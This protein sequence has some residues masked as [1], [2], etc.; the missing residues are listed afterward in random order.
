M[1]LAFLHADFVRETTPLAGEIETIL[2]AL[3]GALER[4]EG[5]APLWRRLLNVL[6]TVKGNCGIVGFAAGQTLAHAME[7]RAKRAQSAPVD[8]QLATARAL[9]PAADALRDAIPTPDAATEKVRTATR[10]LTDSSDAVVEEAARAEQTPNQEEVYASYAVERIADVRIGAEKLDRLLE[11]AGELATH[12]TRVVGVV[13]S[14]AERVAAS[15]QEAAAAL[16]AVDE[17]GKTIAEFRSGITQARLLPL[18][19]AINRFRRLVRDLCASTGK[20]AT[21]E[22]VG[23]E[24]VVDKTIVDAIG[25]PL[26][27]VLRNAVDH[28]LESPSARIAAGKGAEGH[29]SLGIR[30]RGGELLF[31]IRDDGRGIARAKLATRARER[32]VS[33]EG[34]SDTD[35]VELIFLPDISTA[36]KVSEISG[37]GVG[38]DVARK[39][40]E[41][42]GGAIDVVSEEGRGTEFRIRVPLTLTL[43]RVLLVQRRD[44]VYA[45]GLT[46]VF[47]IVRGTGAELHSIDRR[48]FL[49]FRDKLVPCRDLAAWLGIP[50]TDDAAGPGLCVLVDDDSRTGA[51]LVDAVLGQQDIVLK[52]LDPTLGKPGGISGATVLADGRVVM[53]LDARALAGAERP[54]AT[55]FGRLEPA[56]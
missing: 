30:Q 54:G 39:A 8:E 35:L 10:M 47:A 50:G 18:T 29:L 34:W 21:F 1:D 28:G 15:D 5:A 20:R 40:V 41:R 2:L 11:L 51:I 7:D 55:A 13:R 9:F 36:E 49:R 16:D 25:E 46:A 56:P 33:T 24:T 23:A 3:E 4:D 38:L 48:S 27:H 44:E 53:V 32:G 37:R 19:S 6:H 52:E 17:L 26:L 22:I 12:H 43:Q 42:I 31:T 14:L 45:L